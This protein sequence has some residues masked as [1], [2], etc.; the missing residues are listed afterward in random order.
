MN[1]NDFRTALAEA[2]EGAILVSYGDG[3]KPKGLA[4]LALGIAYNGIRRHQKA[5][6]PYST[7]TDGVHIQIK[8]GYGGAVGKWVS[9][10]VPKVEETDNPAPD[11]EHR[12]YRLYRYIEDLPAAAR[13][14]LIDY[15]RSMVGKDYD[16]LQ[17]VGI[18]T[19]EQKWIPKFLRKWLG[20]RLQKPGMLEVCSTLAIK[21][22]LE[23]WARMILDDGLSEAPMPLSDL[24]MDPFDIP[25]AAFE[26]STTMRELAAINT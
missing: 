24:G 3:P 9:A 7:K 26:H 16:W 17:L 10:T 1:T 6:F 19:H 14:A 21:S 2:P 20:F 18:A 25:P 23:G 12:K 8:V 13:V 15:A 11:L 4:G 22:L 5:L